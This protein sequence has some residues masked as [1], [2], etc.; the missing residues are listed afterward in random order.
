MILLHAGSVY[1]MVWIRSV[2]NVCRL[3]CIC[4]ATRT[5]RTAHTPGLT[6]VT[7]ML[8]ACSSVSCASL[9]LRRVIN[10]IIL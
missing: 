7:I 2:I 10:G 1:M 5:R 9:C 8:F 4:G 3:L 6:V